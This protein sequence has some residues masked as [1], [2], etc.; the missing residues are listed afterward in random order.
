[1]FDQYNPPF[2]TIPVTASETDMLT[3]HQW[4]RS[5]TTPE[6]KMLASFQEGWILPLSAQEKKGL[7][8]EPLLLLRNTGCV[9]SEGSSFAKGFSH[10]FCKVNGDELTDE[11][12]ARIFVSDRGEDWMLVPGSAAVIW[13][14]YSY[15]MQYLGELG[16]DSDT[17]FYGKI[18]IT[19]LTI[20]RDSVPRLDKHADDLSLRAIQYRVEEKILISRD[21]LTE[22]D[23]P[24]EHLKGILAS[25]D[26]DRYGNALEH[27]IKR[28]TSH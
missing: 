7:S 19:T 26:L 13:L 24:L 23:R 14:Q 8:G 3:K 17:Y 22:D 1:M 28:A 12:N 4:Y 18:L 16:Q 6:G 2:L 27:A 15:K 10:Q 11:Y 25:H 5:H 9:T 20:K 21:W